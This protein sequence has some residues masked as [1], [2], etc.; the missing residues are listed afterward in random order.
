MGFVDLFGQDGIDC[1]DHVVKQNQNIAITRGGSI[2]VGTQDEWLGDENERAQHREGEALPLSFFL[3]LME[4]NYSTEY[5]KN[6]TCR[7]NERSIEGGRS[8]QPFVEDEQWEDAPD[9][10]HDQIQGEFFH[11]RPDFVIPP[12]KHGETED[13]C[14][15][16]AEI[17]ILGG[18][19]DTQ[20]RFDDGEGG[21]PDKSV[22]E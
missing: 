6:G 13:T 20:G 4:K 21:T 11:R 8:L 19:N 16:E 7:T 5:D 3:S 15:Q 9:E 22:V 14:D 10:L 2:G 1:P 12:D 18:A 17:E